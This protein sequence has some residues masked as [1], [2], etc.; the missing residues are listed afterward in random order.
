M[1]NNLIIVYILLLLQVSCGTDEKII[2]QITC[3]TTEVYGE[4][5]IAKCMINHNHCFIYTKTDNSHTGIK[6]HPNFYPP[7]VLPFD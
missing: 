4:Y 3:P 1:N 5:L 2:E 7:V 6:C